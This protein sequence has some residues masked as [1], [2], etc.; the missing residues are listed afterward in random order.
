GYPGVVDFRGS[1]SGVRRCVIMLWFMWRL[2][3]TAR[4]AL[5]HFLHP[6]SISRRRTDWRVQK[7]VENPFLLRVRKS[8]R[9]KIVGKRARYSRRWDEGSDRHPSPA[10]AATEDS[11]QVAVGGLQHRGQAHHDEAAFT[12]AGGRAEGI[13]QGN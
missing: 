7:A 3:P 4:R 9:V 6:V 8:Y 5:A 10:A 11:P 12:A 2:P 1:L 13:V